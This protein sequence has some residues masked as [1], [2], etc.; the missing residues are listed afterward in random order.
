MD[1]DDICAPGIDHGDELM[2]H[3]S[4]SVTSGEPATFTMTFDGARKIDFIAIGTGL[5]DAS[6]T[7]TLRVSDIE[8]IINEESS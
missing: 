4:I 2:S 5:G 8:V 1:H 6:W 3:Q 7:G